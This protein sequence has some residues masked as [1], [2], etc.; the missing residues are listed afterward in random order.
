M[1]K[2]QKP[3]KKVVKK[4]KVVIPQIKQE[5]LPVGV[6]AVSVALRSLIASAGWAEIKRILN[7]N[8]KYLEKCILDR[9]EPVTG[10]SITDADIEILRTKRFLNIDLRDTP[11]NYLKKLE[12]EGEIP[13]SYDPYFQTV[14]EMSL[15]PKKG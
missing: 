8:I 11:E 2:S 10:E 3:T 15:P 14:E 7:E 12:Q 5:L 4:S 9:K 1:S 13:E 6:E